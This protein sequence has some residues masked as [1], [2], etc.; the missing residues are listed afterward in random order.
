MAGGLAVYLAGEAM[1]RRRLGG[2]AVAPALLTGAACLLTVPL[3]TAVSG[4]AQL[5]GLTALLVAWLA[6]RAAREGGAPA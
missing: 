2:G 6:L 5:A 3:G 1:F 4:L